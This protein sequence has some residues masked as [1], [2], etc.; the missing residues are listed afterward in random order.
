[1]T[2]VTSLTRSSNSNPFSSRAQVRVLLV[3]GAV[4]DAHAV[5]SAAAYGKEPTFKMLS[6]H[7]FDPW[8]QVSDVTL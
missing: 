8:A 7:G 4:P 1:M 5:Y 2:D 6:E 3:K